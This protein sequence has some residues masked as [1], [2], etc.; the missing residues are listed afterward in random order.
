MDLNINCFVSGLKS[1]DKFNKF[2]CDIEDVYEKLGK[3]K[4]IKLSSVLRTFITNVN[5]K[6]RFFFVQNTAFK[7]TSILIG[8]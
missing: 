3:L 8:I 4:H 6:S 5:H 7:N 1:P 2:I